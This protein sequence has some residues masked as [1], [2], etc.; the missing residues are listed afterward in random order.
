ML[1]AAG[2]AAAAGVDLDLDLDFSLDEAPARAAVPSASTQPAPIASAPDNSLAF[3]A[4]SLP[5]SPAPAAAAAD[6]LMNFD[7]GGLSLDLGTPSE[8]PD[9]GNED[10]LAT[11]LAL[12]DEFKAIG[13]TD[14]ARALIEEII[15]EASG[16]MKSRAQKALAALG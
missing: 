2:A 15:A 4:P 8:Q 13:D 1:S 7:M 16:D 5:A 12:A 14:G 9:S 11:K 3:E 6:N 10:P